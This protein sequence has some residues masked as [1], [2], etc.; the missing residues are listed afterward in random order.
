[1]HEKTD[2]ITKLQKQSLRIILNKLML[3]PSSILSKESDILPF[4]SIVKYHSNV[5]VYKALNNM[6]PEYI[7]LNTC[8]PILNL[9][10]FF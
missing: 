9:F 6:A 5:L 1:V 7:K 10:I 4:H 3:K 2:H 8:I